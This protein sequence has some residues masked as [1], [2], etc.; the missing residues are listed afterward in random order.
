MRLPRRRGK[1]LRVRVT[2]A[3]KPVKVRRGVA[4]VRLRKPGSRVKVVVVQRV[5][6]GGQVRTFRSFRVYR[7]CRR[8]A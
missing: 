1:V 7:V 2:V 6:E 5:R 4:Y 8:A 3:G